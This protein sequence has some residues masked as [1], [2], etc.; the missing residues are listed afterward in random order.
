MVDKFVQDVKTYCKKYDL[1]QRT[2][3]PTIVDMTPLTNITPLEPFMKWGL[4]FM[5]PFKQI[6]QRRNKY[7]LVAIDYVTKWVE[8]VA[9]KDD[10]AKSTAW[11]IYDSIIC[12][13]GCPLELVTNQGSHFMNKTMEA[14]VKEFVIKH[15]KS[16]T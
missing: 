12:R 6:T 14:V 15:R 13:F 10:S 5:G 4:D 11:F 2:T 7:I 9:S 3:R 16:T 8:A 1:C